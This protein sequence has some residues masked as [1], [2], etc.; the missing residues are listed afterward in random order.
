MNIDPK[1]EAGKRKP[2]LQLIPPVLN[3]EVAAALQHGAEKYGPWNWRESRVGLMTYIGAIRR[4]CDALLDGEDRDPE[5][6][7]THL[8]H[9]A[10][11]CA[12]VLDAQEHDKIIDNRP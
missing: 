3:S 8:G 6:G 9:I 4:H 10:A 12:I 5:S 11:N 7:I 1:G 2:Q